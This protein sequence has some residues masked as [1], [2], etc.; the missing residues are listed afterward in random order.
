MGNSP[1]WLKVHS[2]HGLHLSVCLP[3]S[4]SCTALIKL[5]YICFCNDVLSSY[6]YWVR[7]S[8][9][10]WRRACTAACAVTTRIIHGFLCGALRS[11]F[12]D[13]VP[14]HCGAV[15][16]LEL[17]MAVRERERGRAGG[18]GSGTAADRGAKP[19][20]A[21]PEVFRVRREEL[22]IMRQPCVLLRRQVCVD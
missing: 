4:R 16:T 2:L 15:R 5:C 8:C 13:H 11:T 1:H 20:R 9:R 21:E 17:L 10:S 14:R 19:S 12:H 3:C 22:L 7:A 6:L 18:A